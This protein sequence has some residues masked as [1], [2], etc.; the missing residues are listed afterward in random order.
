MGTAGALRITRARLD[1]L[2][3]RTRRGLRRAAFG[4]G[5]LLR[6]SATLAGLHRDG[7]AVLRRVADELERISP[8]AS[9]E[10]AMERALGLVD[11]VTSRS[12]AIQGLGIDARRVRR[13]LLRRRDVH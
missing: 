11:G 13:R 7:R 10:R 12:R 1:C 3:R 4:A 2:A 6:S 8:E 5:A 9:I